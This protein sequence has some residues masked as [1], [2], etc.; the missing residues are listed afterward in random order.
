MTFKE[1]DV[2]GTFGTRKRCRQPQLRHELES[3]DGK[4]DTKAARHVK[5]NASKKHPII[6]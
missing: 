6:R 4:S 5:T 1:E 3:F 2:R